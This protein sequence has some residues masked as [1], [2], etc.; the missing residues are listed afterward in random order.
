MHRPGGF[1]RGQSQETEIA[2]VKKTGIRREET[3][4]DFVNILI[5]S[6]FTACRKGG[7]GGEKKALIQM[8]MIFPIVSISQRILT[9]VYL[10]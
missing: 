3:K 8:L 4:L 7:G 2:I 5:P 10:N 1:R 6:T 9:E